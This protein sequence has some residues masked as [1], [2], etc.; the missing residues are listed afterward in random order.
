MLKVITVLLMPL[1]CLASI[2]P[3]NT[4]GIWSS[5]Y[6]ALPRTG[7]T[8]HFKLDE[9][10]TGILGD[11]RD[12]AD[13]NPGTSEGNP[14]VNPAKMNR[15]VYFDGVDDYIKDSGL[16]KPVTA[17][18][19]SFWVRF[20]DMNISTRFAGDWHQAVN[21]DRWLFLLSPGGTTAFYI[22]NSN[23][24]QTAT[25]I[26]GS[27]LYTWYHLVATYD[28]TATKV[29]VNNSLVETQYSCSGNLN[30][31]TYPV[32]LGVQKYTGQSGSFFKGAIDDFRIYDRAL[33]PSEI[34]QIYQASTIHKP[35]YVYSQDRL[36]SKPGNAVIPKEITWTPKS[37]S[38]LQYWINADNAAGTVSRITD[39]SSNGFV[40]YPMYSGRPYKTRGLNNLPVFRFDG[41]YM[42]MTSAVPAGVFTDITGGA[43]LFSVYTLNNNPAYN[44]VEDEEDGWWRYGGDSSS[45]P[46][47]FILGRY[48]Q[49]RSGV[50][51]N[52]NHITE[53]IANGTSYRSSNDGVFGS[54][55]TIT[56]DAPHTLVLGGGII[57]GGK[58]FKGD[59]CE[60]LIYNR[61]L[62]LSERQT[63][64]DY[65]T[66]KW[67]LTAI[68][69]N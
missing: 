10:L 52:G 8:T 67:G 39:Q 47:L 43:T 44:I 15:G 21:A 2:Y 53:I 3:S 69:E 28:G 12:D 17:L 45:Y 25:I 68:V 40:F 19:I 51:F 9:S 26:W 56:F 16:N 57:D 24:T 65:L 1:F 23:E 66:T 54:T 4:V 11:V 18:S 33:S 7:L 29:Y 30:Y 5:S 34:T 48:N 46:S 22:A 14:V 64:M 27:S 6:D 59:I 63:V 31:S 37:V 58:I 62:S 38:G 61:A 13:S 42:Q 35:V 55:V 20:D 41:T 50:P 49:Y 36:I 32:Q 60:V